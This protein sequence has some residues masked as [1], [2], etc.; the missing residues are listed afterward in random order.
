[1]LYTSWFD[2]KVSVFIY[3]ILLNQ[4]NFITAKVIPQDRIYSFYPKEQLE[5]SGSVGAVQIDVKLFLKFQRI[6]HAD[7]FY[8]AS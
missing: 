3:L 7:T 6:V 5:I 4:Q 1:M 2:M 8:L